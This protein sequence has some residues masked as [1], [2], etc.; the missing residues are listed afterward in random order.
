[1]EKEQL[2]ITKEQAADLANGDYDNTIFEVI[3]NKI[4]GT[5]RWT[6][7]YELIIKRLSDGKFFKDHYQTG[8]TES[9]DE[10]AY[11]YSEP[12]FLE[13][14]PVEKTITVY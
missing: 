4:V 13:V 10:G 5:S 8:L 6:G 12:K 11:E 9:Q 1:M 14:F 3:S 2:Q 7:R